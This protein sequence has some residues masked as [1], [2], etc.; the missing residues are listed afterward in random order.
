[1]PVT[2]VGT[3]EAIRRPGLRMV[4]V[5][6][7]PS[8]WGEAAKGILHVKRLDWVAVRLDYESEA[9]KEWT[10]QRSGPVA[11]YEK[12]RPRSGWAEILL[13]AERLAPQP[14]LI[15][16]DAADRALMFGMAHEILGEQGL[17]WS[18]RLQL[19]HLGL[20]KNGGF[21]EAVAQYLAKK[22]GY[23]PEAGAAAPARVASLLRMLASRLSAQASK[24]SAYY[25]GNA[26]S[27]LDIYSATAMAMF[28][29]LA[30]EQCAMHPASRSAFETSDSE[31]AAA[32]D[33]LLFRH[34]DMV[35]AKH[36][37]LP[38]SL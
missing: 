23:S 17:A 14:S 7:V 32:L 20:Q 31:I 16:R 26:L 35:Y 34:R 22:Y 4:V 29:P 18:R 11:V 28:K 15:P 3:E 24:G 21:R 30:Q 27:A 19:I 8:P 2:Y 33:P 37:E 9:Q 36:L 25:L 1:M 12:E 13:L 5:G 6:N 10:G 38:L